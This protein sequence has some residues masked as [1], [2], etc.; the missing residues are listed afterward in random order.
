M[1]P[2]K[3][4]TMENE[5]KKAIWQKPE[6]IDLDIIKTDAKL[7]ALDESEFMGPIGS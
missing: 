2:I 3:I 1:N 7:E 4:N 5:I 6:I